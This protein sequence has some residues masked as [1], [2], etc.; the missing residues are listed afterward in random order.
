MC[1][2]EELAWEWTRIFIEFGECTPTLALYRNNLFVER[3]GFTLK[4]TVFYTRCGAD[5]WSILRCQW[6]NLENK[7]I[8]EF[9]ILQSDFNFGK[10]IVILLW[11]DWSFLFH[12]I[13]I[14]KLDLKSWIKSDLVSNT[15]S[16]EYYFLFCTFN[17]IFKKREK[18][19]RTI[20]NRLER[21]SSAER[22]YLRYRTTPRRHDKEHSVWKSW[23]NGS[24]VLESKRLSFFESGSTL[25]VVLAKLFLRSSHS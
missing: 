1:T 22:I 21:V 3:I 4:F 10:W 20:D 13:R 19:N 7:S 8:R 9:L 24:I 23:W 5:D 6:C 15:E 11:R 16:F 14:R 12:N 2:W 18:R 25:R 17:G